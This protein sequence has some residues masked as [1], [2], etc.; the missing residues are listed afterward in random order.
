[1]TYDVKLTFKMAI[2]YP[3]FPF[4]F[5]EK[6]SFSLLKNAWISFGST[7]EKK[8]AFLCEIEFLGVNRAT[9]GHT[10]EWGITYQSLFTL[11][12][13]AVCLWWELYNSYEMEFEI[14]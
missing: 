9:D 3:N 7:I 11:P 1:M 5:L 10:I 13:N 6:F 8:T 14:F 12:A 2:I 4:K